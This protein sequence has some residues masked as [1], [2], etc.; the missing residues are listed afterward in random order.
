M[1]P[2][3]GRVVSTGN[4]AFETLT[5]REKLEGTYPFRLDKEGHEMGSED[6]ADATPEV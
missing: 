4:A 1:T 5:D 6:R 2:P 3:T